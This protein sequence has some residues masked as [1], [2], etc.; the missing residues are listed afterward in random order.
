V[1][2]RFVTAATGRRTRNEGETSTLHQ[3]ALDGMALVESGKLEA[4]IPPQLKDDAH[5][6][7][8]GGVPLVAGDS[9]GGRRG[10][11]AVAGSLNEIQLEQ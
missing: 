6:L 10:W 9:D 4:S 3:T 1:C 7:R 2:P 5:Q 11:R 8:A